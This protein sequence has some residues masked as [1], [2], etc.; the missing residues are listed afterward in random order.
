VSGS[1]NFST[2]SCPPGR[3]G[4]TLSGGHHS[5]QAALDDARTAARRC[6]VYR[7]LIEATSRHANDVIADADTGRPP[8]PFQRAEQARGAVAVDAVVPDLLARR[9]MGAAL[10]E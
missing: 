5:G 2:P 10:L 7:T 3:A 4:R 8:H 1:R 6:D 9:D